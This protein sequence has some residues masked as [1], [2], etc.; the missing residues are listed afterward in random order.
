[1][2][3]KEILEKAINLAIDGGW[4]QPWVYYHGNTKN[5][6]KLFKQWLGNVLIGGVDHEYYDYEDFICV[7]TDILYSHDFAKTIWGEEIYFDKDNLDVSM[8]GDKYEEQDF[9]AVRGETGMGIDGDPSYRQLPLWQHH[10]QQMV[11]SDD[12]IKYLG[13][14]I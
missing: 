13:K 1:M 10:L 12:P 4:K 9:M 11:I 2:S 3:N 8:V 7:A 5:K 14:N 6:D